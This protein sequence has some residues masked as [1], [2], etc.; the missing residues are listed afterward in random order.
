MKKK[1]FLI[2]TIPNSLFFFKNQIK[3]LNQDFDVTLISSPGEKLESIAHNENVKYKSISMKRNISINND[4]ISFIKFFWLFLIQR[5]A[6]IHCNTPKAALLG[7]FSG[8]ITRVPTRIYYIHGLRY[9]GEIEK[10]QKI[11]IAIEKL[12]CFCATDI[13]AVSNGVKQ[14]AKENLTNKKISIIHNGSPNGLP[15][16]DFLVANYNKKKIY[17]EL[18]ISEED[19]V[20]GFVGRLVGDKGI[21]ELVYAFNQLEQKILN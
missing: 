21:N 15:V 3:K 13:I 5:P 19:F 8:F 16:Q 4:I 9:E 2:T 12:C 10:K 18:A 14:K 20:F 11:L 1:L 6:V 17:Q 7:L